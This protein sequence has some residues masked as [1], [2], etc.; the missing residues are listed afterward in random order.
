[1]ELAQTTTQTTRRG[2]RPA[3][4]REDVLETALRLY[5]HGERER[6]D[7]EGRNC[8]E[9]SH[10]MFLLVNPLIPACQPRAYSGH[11]RAAIA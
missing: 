11:A 4:S 5:L 7:H 10:R 8:N 3:A 9:L 1:V 6:R 2:R